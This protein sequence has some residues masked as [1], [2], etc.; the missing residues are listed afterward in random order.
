MEQRRVLLHALQLQADGVPQGI[1]RIEP[2][3]GF[4]AFIG[5]DPAISTGH[6]R[7]E[8]Y[9]QAL[10]K[11]GIGFEPGLVL[12][13]APTR[14]GGYDNVERLLQMKKRPTAALCF[15]D[16]VA[17]GVIEALQQAGLRAGQQFGVVGFNN[18]PDAAQN[19]PGLTTI[20]TSPRELGA[21]AADLLLK[22][23]EQPDSQIRTMILLPRLI[24]RQSCGAESPMN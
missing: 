20:D 7:I 6:E 14:R 5:G 13:S 4:G 22:R 10:R 2:V 19:L 15:N 21:T 9:R 11:L 17:F 16:V 24:V 23:I 1:G 18:V 12:P 8:G 3:H